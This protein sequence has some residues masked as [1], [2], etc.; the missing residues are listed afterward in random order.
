M[1]V[2]LVHDWLTGMRGGEKVLEAFCDRFPDAPIYTIVHRPGSV[3]P[4]IESHRIFP[5]FVQRL[6]RGVSSY[7]RYLPLLPAAI[8]R[9]DLRG[10]D[11]VLSTSHCVAKGAR[12]H[13]GT[14]H[15]CYCHTPMRY[16]WPAYEEYFGDKRFG[17]P[18]SWLLPLLATA[19]RTW[20]VAANHRVDSFAANSRHVAARIARWYGRAARVIHPWVDTERFHPP[21][22]PGEGGYD[23]ILSALVPYKRIDLALDAYRGRP[24]Q[25]L[26]VAGS[27]VEKERLLRR[28]PQ[29]VRFF[30]WLSPE[31]TV[32]MIQ[33]C[34]ALVFPGEEDFGIVPVEAMACGKPV[35]AFRSGGAMET[36]VEGET[37][38][39]FDRPTPED[40][41][42]ALD[43]LREQRWDPPAIRAHALRFGRERF[44]REVD[45][46]LDEEGVGAD[47]S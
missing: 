45:A 12:V 41:A 22:E 30:D 5:S 33:S 39:F 40:L 28:A 26:V 18:A 1:R 31:E 9:F 27:G 37:G 11:L 3:S 4:V 8:E 19:L 24:E 14:R 25:R 13:P 38:L 6:P 42:G 44:D 15:L 46:W 21:A 20:D 32:R 2:A 43:R 47:P 23:L 29:N 10:F 35:V 34:R 16:V 36:V 7:Q 17:A